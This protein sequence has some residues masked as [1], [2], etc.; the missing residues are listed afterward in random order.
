MQHCII[1]HFS[2][3]F[4]ITDY[5][6][7]FDSVPAKLVCTVKNTGEAPAALEHTVMETV[8]RPPSATPPPTPGSRQSQAAQSPVVLH[9][10][11][12]AMTQQ[13]TSFAFAHTVADP[14]M[15]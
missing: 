10:V 13:D 12:M 14:R 2:F 1:L 15:I 7:N 5:I 11:G 4:V 9:F 6:M 8:F 3:G